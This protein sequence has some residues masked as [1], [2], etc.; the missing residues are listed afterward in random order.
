MFTIY[1]FY[2]LLNEVEVEMVGRGCVGGVEMVRRGCVGGNECVGVCNDC[3]FCFHIITQL[4]KTR[5]KLPSK[6]N[7][8]KKALSYSKQLHLI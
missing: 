3:N 6:E 1:R 8:M 4:I 7:K 5:K 2:T